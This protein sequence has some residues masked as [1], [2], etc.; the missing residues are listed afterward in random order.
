MSKVLRVEE[1]G[2]GKKIPGPDSGDGSP[3]APY[4]VVCATVTGS[5]LIRQVTDTMAFGLTGV[6]YRLA[7]RFFQV[8]VTSTA[9]ILSAPLPNLLKDD[10]VTSNSLFL[11]LPTTMAPLPACLQAW[12]TSSRRLGERDPS[13]SVLFTIF[14]KISGLLFSF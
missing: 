13:C 8:L 3:I 12:N 14:G 4:L 7:Y 5:N 11:P 1:R 9:D 6:L 10:F 2:E